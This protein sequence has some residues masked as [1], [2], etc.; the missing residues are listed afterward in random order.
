MRVDSFNGRPYRNFW[1]WLRD[2]WHIYF[3][4]MP[5]IGYGWYRGATTE[6]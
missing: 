6:V 5:L 3:V 1:E 4:F 2:G